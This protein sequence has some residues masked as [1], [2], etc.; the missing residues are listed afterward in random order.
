MVRTKVLLVVLIE[1]KVER[2]SCR[3]TKGKTTCP[4]SPLARPFAF[5]L[6]QKTKSSLRYP[7]NLIKV[8]VERVRRGLTKGKMTCLGSP[9]ARPFAFALYQKTTFFV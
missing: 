4:G 2:V 6:Y 5:V 7:L 1:V 9:L 8:K 3:L